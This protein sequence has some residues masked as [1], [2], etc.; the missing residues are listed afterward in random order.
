LK[1]RNG[2]SLTVEEKNGISLTVE[3]KKWNISDS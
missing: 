2:I 1:R 3:E